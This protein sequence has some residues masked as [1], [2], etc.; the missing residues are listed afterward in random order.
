LELLLF[1]KTK[2][3]RKLLVSTVKSAVA[4][5]SEESMNLFECQ[6]KYE[7]ASYLATSQTPDIAFL[8]I[9]ASEDIT[10]SEQVRFKHSDTDML[11]VADPSISPMKYMNPKIRAVSLLLKPINKES[12]CNVVYDFISDYYRKKNDNSDDNVL[13]FENKFGKYAIPFS[14]I[15]YVEVREKRVYVRLQNKEYWQYDSLE[16]I[17]KKLPSYFMRCHRSYIFN[18]N[19]L[20]R[21][22][23]SENIIFLENDICVPLS[24]SYKA[25]V[26]EYFNGLQIL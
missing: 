19:Y 4:M 25:L 16:N 10:L 2:I 15:Y 14:K 12:T 1:D 13:I 3:E 26:K 18:T 7:V 20:T 17:I 6:D 5:K 22:K 23:L 21:I 11:I 24:R 8:E 9:S